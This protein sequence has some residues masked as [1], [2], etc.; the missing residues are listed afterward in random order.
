MIKRLQNRQILQEILTKSSNISNILTI[1]AEPPA[2]SGNFSLRFPKSDRLL[3]AHSVKINGLN[4]YF[5]RIHL[6]QN[7]LAGLN[8]HKTQDDL[9][10]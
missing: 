6:I 1:S 2:L 10:T 3:G 5:R 9:R 8:Y 7:A 4:V